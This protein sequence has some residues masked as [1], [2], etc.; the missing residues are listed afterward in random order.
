MSEIPEE[1]LD[2]FPD[3]VRKIIIDDGLTINVPDLTQLVGS[4]NALHN[5]TSYYAS[6][7]PHIYTMLLMYVA[8]K[9]I[10]GKIRLPTL[11]DDYFGNTMYEYGSHKHRSFS[12]KLNSRNFSHITP[13]EY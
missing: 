4:R 7:R 8:K 6:F 1:V 10:D 5:A 13:N 11:P 12:K 2:D 9:F 3:F